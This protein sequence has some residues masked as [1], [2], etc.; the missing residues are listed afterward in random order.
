MNLVP[1]KVKLF[2]QNM[3]NLREQNQAQQRIDRRSEIA[4]ECVF[5]N[6]F[7]NRYRPKNLDL[8]EREFPPQL[9]N[10]RRLGETK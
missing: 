5:L 2:N 3:D 8:Y 7:S 6:K 10:R 1:A 9:N 4:I